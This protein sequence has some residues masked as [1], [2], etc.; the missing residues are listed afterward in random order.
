MVYGS[1]FVNNK[2]DIRLLTFALTVPLKSKEGSQCY[3]TT[4]PTH[5]SLVTCQSYNLNHLR[6]AISD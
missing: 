5:W 3:Y 4:N 2:P 6:K 1:P